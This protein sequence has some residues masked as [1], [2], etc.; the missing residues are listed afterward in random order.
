MEYPII[1]HIIVQIPVQP[2]EVNILR[3]FRQFELRV[4]ALWL[5]CCG[6]RLISP[7]LSLC[8]YRL[9]RNKQK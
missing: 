6:A 7:C 5:T 1:S 2:D 3:L 9:K 8:L 4:N